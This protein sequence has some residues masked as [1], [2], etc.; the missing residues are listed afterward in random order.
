[1]LRDPFREAGPRLLMQ[2]LPGTLACGARARHRA[3]C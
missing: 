1:M 3:P 2:A